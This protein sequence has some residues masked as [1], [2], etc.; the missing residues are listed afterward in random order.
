M[1]AIA[2]HSVAHT[3]VAANSCNFRDV[4]GVSRY[5]PPTLTKK[6]LSH[7]SCHPRQ[8]CRAI[9]LQRWIALHGGVAATLTPI[10]LHC[11]TKIRAHSAQKGLEVCYCLWGV[12]SR[13][14]PGSYPGPVQVP[15]RVRGGKVIPS[16]FAMCFVLQCFGPIQVPRWGASRPVLVP[17]SS[18][19]FLPGSGLDGPRQT[20]W[21][22]PICRTSGSESVP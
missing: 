6:T 18:R 10:A 2:L 1:N 11:A 17:S 12:P 15:S 16:R 14:S 5:T 19:A 3:M 13:P 4:A 20:S 8:C 22:L 21:P 7:L 9:S